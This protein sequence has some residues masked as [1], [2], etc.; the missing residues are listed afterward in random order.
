MKLRSITKI[1]AIT[2]LLS[3]LCGIYNFIRLVRQITWSANREVLLLQ[4]VYLVANITLT[5]FLFTL[6]SR[7]KQD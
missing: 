7:Q 1:A 4:P 5:I 2:Q 3:V 6:V